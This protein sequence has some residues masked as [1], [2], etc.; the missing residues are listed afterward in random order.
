MHRR[1][2]L[3][4][5]T[6]GFTLFAQSAAPDARTLETLL[7]EVREL[8]LAIE[9]S[10]L[11]GARAQLAIGELQLQESAVARVSQQLNEAR[12]MAV[13]SAGHVAQLT[14]RVKHLE[15]SRTSPEWVPQAKHDELESLI[16]QTKLEL[17]EANAVEQQRAAREADLANQL[18]AAQNQVA[19]SR[20]RIA[21]MERA[22]DAALQQMLKP[23]P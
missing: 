17:E 21:E 9:R 6:L 22:L 11:L 12:G 13:G 19:D 2:A 14:E 18:Q 20:S 23:H 8:R 1:F 4:F 10:S 7:S 15:E 3:L 16:R 5:A